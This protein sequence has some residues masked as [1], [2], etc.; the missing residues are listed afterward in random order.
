MHNHDHDNSCASRQYQYLCQQQWLRVQQRQQQ[1]QHQQQ[2]RRR[3]TSPQHFL[4]ILAL[5]QNHDGVVWEELEDPLFILFDGSMARLRVCQEF[6][7]MSSSTTA[8]TTSSSTCSSMNIPSKV[9]CELLN[10]IAYV[11]RVSS[12]TS[13][14]DH[15]HDMA[16]HDQYIS[17][18]ACFLSIATTTTSTSTM[19]TVRRR[20]RRRRGYPYHLKLLVVKTLLQMF[21]GSTNNDTTTTTTTTTTLVD[22]IVVE[23][24]YRFL[25]E[26]SSVSL[27]SSSMVATTVTKH[28]TH[29]INNNE[30]P[31][32]TTIPSQRQIQIQ[33]RRQL[34]LLLYE[35]RAKCLRQL[36][37]HNHEQKE[38]IQ[39]VVEKGESTAVV[40]STGAKLIEYGIQKSNTAIV[41]QITKVTKKVKH[42]IDDNNDNDNDND[43]DNNANNSTNTNTN[44]NT[45][46]TDPNNTDTDNIEK[47]RHHDN[48]DPDSTTTTTMKKAITATTC[49]NNNDSHDNNMVRA[50]AFSGTTKRATEIAKNNTQHVAQSTVDA[51][52]SGLYKVGNKV[53]EVLTNEE[54]G[55][56]AL[57]TKEECKAVIKSAS[58]VGLAS[59]GAVVLVT[60]AIIESGR[61]VNKKT[62]DATVDVVRYK[63]GSDVGDVAK[64]VADSYT[65]VIETMGNVTLI[66][67]GSKIITK[68]AKKAGKDQV[69]SSSDGIEEKATKLLQN[70]EH[71][72]IGSIKLVTTQQTVGIESFDNKNA[73]A[74]IGR[75]NNSNN[76]HSQQV[77]IC[78]ATAATTAVPTTVAAINSI[79][80]TASSTKK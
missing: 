56:L 6:I 59:I 31:L 53:E 70:L 27:P 8:T 64:D 45:N 66:R 42:W 62:V 21:I 51:T 80:K 72:A 39:R 54:H 61:S 43:N 9:K 12:N 36:E 78:N 29:P 58:K 19:G 40:I 1:L 48:F 57:S 26:R 18:I 13:N 73:K 22:P 69:Q 44:T 74:K 67:S 33:L 28:N 35:I 60:D 50:R 5:K 77:V 47:Q 75:N 15:D 23:D 38:R 79:N 17:T 3:L 11:L 30:T 41:G 10:S 20:R 55:S 32:S 63:Y 16:L 2:S 49:N 46:N 71:H 76:R 25:T 7:T 34:N 68:V 24:V 52:L 37:E 4:D 65:N 14:T